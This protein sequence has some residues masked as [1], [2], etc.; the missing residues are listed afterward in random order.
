MSPTTLGLTPDD[1]TEAESY[2]VLGAAYFSARRASEVLFAGATDD[3]YKQV[4]DKTVKLLQDGLYEYVEGFILS[5]LERNV[6]GR[7]RAM[8]DDTVNALLTGEAWAMERYPYA[9]Y[10]DGEKVRAAVAKH[11]GDVLLMQ[12]IADLEKAIARLREQL[13]W[14]R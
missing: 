3:P 6:A 9:A 4:V 14:S 7:V 8:V 5:D 1:I 13:E 12:R 10:Q 2:P 11:G